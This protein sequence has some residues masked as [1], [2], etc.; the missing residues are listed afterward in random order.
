[1]ITWV[2]PMVYTNDLRF[3]SDLNLSG[4]LLKIKYKTTKMQ[5]DIG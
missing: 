4:K 1:M 2:K 5:T 3:M